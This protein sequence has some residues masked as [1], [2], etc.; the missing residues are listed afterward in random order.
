MFARVCVLCLPT[1]L[2]FVTISLEPSGADASDSPTDIK[3]SQ[4]KIEALLN[5]IGEQDFSAEDELRDL[6]ADQVQ[7]S[8]A[9]L[10]P[11]AKDSKRKK[12]ILHILTELNPQHD[13]SDI[14]K[15]NLQALARGG[16]DDPD[17]E[18]A[19]GALRLL[20]RIEPLKETQDLIAKKVNTAR[21][22]LQVQYFELL[23]NRPDLLREWLEAPVPLVSEQG[24]RLHWLVLASSA[25]QAC[26]FPPAAVPPGF[27]EQIARLMEVDP[28]VPQYAV[29][30]LV[31]LHA[32]QAL[33][34]LKRIRNTSSSENVRIAADVAILMLDPE[35]V[36]RQP[37]LTRRLQEALES[38]RQGPERESEAAALNYWLCFVAVMKPDPQL[39]DALWDMNA[40]FGI[41]RLVA[42]VAMV[43]DWSPS[44]GRPALAVL[45]RSKPEDVK[46]IVAASAPRV[47]YDL[48][49]A[50]ERVL[51]RIKRGGTDKG[52]EVLVPVA[53]QVLAA[54]EETE[55][56]NSPI[57][58]TQ[59]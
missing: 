56:G 32:M 3:A 59:Y 12:L 17:V 57:R 29:P 49:F 43:H 38:M 15:P 5:R 24:A 46:A 11:K 58:G 28:L 34:D 18:V 51:A 21:D 44:D 30:C 35:A 31:R 1:V 25:M 39:L 54:A 36:D 20:R 33:P 9:A 16:L 52:D 6:P 14:V 26:N 41:Q 27:A 7:E 10:W 4:T 22:R 8:L 47:I 48:K 37:K 42:V 40:P 2:V 50:S 23:G 19:G 55:K 45:R 13:N 53:R